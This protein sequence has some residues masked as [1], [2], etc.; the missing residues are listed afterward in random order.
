MEG[1]FEAHWIFEGRGE[2]VTEVRPLTQA[3]FA[4]LWD[5]VAASVGGDAVFGKCLV[6]D[7]TRLVDPG[8]YHVI[9]TTQVWEGRLQ[10][11][12]F[13]VPTGE[14]GP[15]FA[16]WL[17]ELVVPG[18][19]QNKRCMPVSLKCGFVLRPWAARAGRQD[20]TPHPGGTPILTGMTQESGLPSLASKTVPRLARHPFPWRTNVHS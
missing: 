10:R 12:T 8:L 14:M 3:D 17:N 5:G 7:P 6:A 18:Q 11:R 9:T 15:M 16:A 20:G 2:T 4:L 13:M 19:A 1:G